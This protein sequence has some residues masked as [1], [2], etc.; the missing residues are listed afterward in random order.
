MI[1]RTLRR[2]VGPLDGQA[3]QLKTPTSIV[4]PSP[5]EFRFETLWPYFLRSILWDG[6]VWFWK[7]VQE[8]LATRT[9]KQQG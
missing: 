5:I 4:T 7:L 1:F 9:D 2:E 8:I 6:M 3:T